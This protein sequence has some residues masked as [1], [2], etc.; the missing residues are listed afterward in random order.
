MSK[1]ID[2]HRQAHP[3]EPW[4]WNPEWAER[5]LLPLEKPGAIVGFWVVG[6]LVLGTCYLIPRSV[7][8]DLSD[9]FGMVIWGLAL[10]LA[11]FGVLALVM[12]VNKTRAFRRYRQVWLELDTVPGIIGD[13][14]SATLRTLTGFPPDAQAALLLL[15][16]SR[17]RFKQSDNSYFKTLW[18]QEGAASVSG[19]DIPLVFDLPA[20]MPEC[21]L[22]PPETGEP[23]ITWDLQ[24]KVKSAD[25]PFSAL[26]RVPVFKKR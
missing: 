2:E 17:T 26:F 12:A 1:K 7:G 19:R 15:C 5:R 20:D 8:A 14:F 24:V 9:V 6:V 25:V 22:E 3:D 23:W 16:T 13:R 10:L 4:L 11:L 18:R 21:Q